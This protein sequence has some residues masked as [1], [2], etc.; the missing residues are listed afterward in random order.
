M[1]KQRKTEKEV[2]AGEK[3][4][5]KE[6]TLPATTKKSSKNYYSNNIVTILYVKLIR[7]YT[8]EY[9]FNFILKFFMQKL[10]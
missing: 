7:L 10:I 2:Y 8:L 5:P 6:M 3:N 9:Y 1:K 4:K